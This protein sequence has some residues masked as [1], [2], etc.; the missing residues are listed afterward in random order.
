MKE[1]DNP[2]G[3]PYWL[4]VYPPATVQWYFQYMDFDG[5]WMPSSL[6][7]SDK[8]KVGQTPFTYRKPN[9]I[10]AWITVVFTT[11]SRLYGK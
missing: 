6:R 5:K 1:R 3:E 10:R 11:L 7:A 8:V 4:P 9:S 2:F